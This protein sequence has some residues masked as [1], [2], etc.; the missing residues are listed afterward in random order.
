MLDGDVTDAVE[1]GSLGLN[2]DHIDV[3]TNSWGPN[4]DGRTMEG[5][6]HL[7]D[8]AIRHGI[9]QGRG[10]LG[11]IF[12]FASGN[13]GRYGDNCNC[14]GYTNSPFTLS[15]GSVRY[16]LCCPGRETLPPP[17]RANGSVVSWRCL[18]RCFLPL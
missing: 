11:S 1:A 17:G 12:L 9:E 6:A 4:D 14:D 7:A 5:P 15:I 8:L 18:G 2:P 10:G 13:G 3:Y 16:V